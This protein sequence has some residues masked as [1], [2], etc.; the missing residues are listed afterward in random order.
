MGFQVLDNGLAVGIGLVDGEFFGQNRHDNGLEGADPGWQDE[1]RVVSVDHNHDTNGAGGE[2]PRGLPGNLGL[3]RFVLKVNVKHFAKVLSEVVRGGSLNG[4]PGNG[5]VRFDRGGL[6]STGKFFLFR[7]VSLNDGDG[8]QVF[9]NTAVQI[10]GLLDHGVGIVVRGV[11]RVSFLPQEFAG[12]QKG[13]GVLKFPP[14]H[15][16]PLVEFEGQIA[17]RTDP[18]AK[19]RVHNRLAGRT[20]R[21]G[22]GQIPITALGDP[23]HLGS[24]ALHV[25]LFLFQTILGHKERKVR[26]LHT[27]LLNLYTQEEAKRNNTIERRA[28]SILFF[29]LV[30]THL[31]IEPFLNEFP[32]LVRPWP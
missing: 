18:I 30:S 32:N 2:S 27:Q 6:V 22:F 9:V 4:P 7:L 31:D 5:N 28:C 23:R 8:Q 11:G 12:S 16:G 26:I 20:D 1:S 13:C 24:K 21:N 3:A 15:I 29:R 19:G 17:M 14:H 25:V 10:E